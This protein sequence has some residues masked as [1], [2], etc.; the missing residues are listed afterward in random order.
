M[1]D[2][3]CVEISLR[4][5]YLKN[6]P[7]ETL[8]FGGGTPS[9][10]TKDQLTQIVENV[11]SNFASQWAEVTLEANPDDLTEAKLED[12]KELGI[13]RLSLGI[14][15]FHPEVLSFYNRLH[16]AE[17]AKSAIS[18]AR[19]I[20]FEKFSI[21]LIYGFPWSDHSLWQ[22]DLQEAIS[23]KPGHISAYALTVEDK[24]ALGNWTRKGKFNPANEDF[25]AEQFEW[26][27][28]TL[29]NAGYV[30]YEVSNFGKPGQ[31]GLHNSNYW[32]GIP[33]LGI[34]PSA[35]SFDGISRGANPASNPIYLRQI[36]SGKSPFIA[37]TLS[38]EESVNEYI[39]TGLRTQWG[40][41]TTQIKAA[42]GVDL[43]LIKEKEIRDLIS[44]GWLIQQDNT[45]TLTKRGLLLADSISAMLFI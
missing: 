10:L 33:Y 5:N 24:T 4:K 27:Q 8:Y 14:Q 23:Q 7:V 11:K 9:L 35:H 45:L 38:K 41:S 25:V 29:E 43:T 26:M 3:I 19:K 22:A 13:D 2:A 28:Q 32:K 15:S 18:R 36:A 37:E 17:E 20:G 40:I 44:Q 39:L 31:F 6:E 1:V 16:T 12:W 21:D 30:Q 34:G 42:W